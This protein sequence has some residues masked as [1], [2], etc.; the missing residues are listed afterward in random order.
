MKTLQD[1]FV[2]V[3]ERHDSA[4]KIAGQQKLPDTDRAKQLPGKNKVDDTLK[5]GL[6]SCIWSVK[7]KS[8]AAE[9]VSAGGL[10]NTF[11]INNR[12]GHVSLHEMHLTF[13]TSYAMYESIFASSLHEG[14][15]GMQDTW[16]CFPLCGRAT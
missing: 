3:K 11:S 4:M 13:F 10:P 8:L 9:M 6:G 12:F 1:I 7:F 15:M 5:K 2:R 16:S 14:K